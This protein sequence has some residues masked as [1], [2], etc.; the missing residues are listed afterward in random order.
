[1]GWV[2]QPQLPEGRY[3]PTIRGSGTRNGPEARNAL[4]SQLGIGQGH[5]LLIKGTWSDEE[6][7]CETNWADFCAW[8]L[9]Q[10]LTW[11]GR[12]GKWMNRI[13]WISRRRRD[14]WLPELC[15]ESVCVRVYGSKLTRATSLEKTS[16]IVFFKSHLCLCRYTLHFLTHILPEF[17]LWMCECTHSYLFYRKHLFCDYLL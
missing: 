16:H 4:A 3:L 17:A 9:A 6:P 2:L 7:S 10:F 14:P 5:F 1:M 8:R 13:P 15:W 12:V 11:H